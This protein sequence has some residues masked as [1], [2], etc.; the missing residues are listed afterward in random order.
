MT[1]FIVIMTLHSLIKDYIQIN[2]YLSSDKIGINNF[3]GQ[4]FKLKNL[5]TFEG[6]INFI[7]ILIGHMFYLGSSS[8]LIC[9][10][11]NSSNALFVMSV[12]T[13]PGE[14][15]LTLI[16]LLASS[17]AI[18]RTAELIAP[19]LAVYPIWPGMRRG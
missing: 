3:S 7:K 12:L 17:M 14:S 10:S 6:L 9:S 1:A 18:D 15:V 19:L 5:L 2:L 8:F 13:S 11:V 16:F 4:V